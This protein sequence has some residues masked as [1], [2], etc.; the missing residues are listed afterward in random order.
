MTSINQSNNNHE[1]YQISHPQDLW[2]ELC[3]SN[4]R[5]LDIFGMMQFI[6]LDTYTIMPRLKMV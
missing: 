5:V 4:N 6:L 1:H 2:H 3:I